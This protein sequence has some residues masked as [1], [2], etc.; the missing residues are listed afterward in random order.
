MEWRAARSSK[1]AYSNGITAPEDDQQIYGYAAYEEFF[2]IGKQK[3][4]AD[5]G[6]QMLRLEFGDG[7][8]Q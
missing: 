6:Y 4:T 8:G 5:Q 1:T 2:E 3:M 7:Y